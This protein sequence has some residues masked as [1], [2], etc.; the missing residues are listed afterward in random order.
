M[1]ALR[2]QWAIIDHRT[3]LAMDPL[4]ITSASVALATAV[5]KTTMEVKKMVGVMN[6]G[7]ESLS[8]LSEEVQIVHAALQSVEN[9]LNE[10]KEAIERYKVDEV[11]TI[12][13]KGCRATLS[14]IE[15]E[16][17]VLFNRKDWKARFMVL[18]KE[19]NMN[20]LLARLCRKRDSIMLLVQL[21]SL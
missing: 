14:C 16:F 2:T 9:A 7:T 21:L 10:D 19:D 18:W 20:K 6:D 3:N 4:S 8:D 13:V 11:F 17:E 15:Q 12:A 5:Y 1:P